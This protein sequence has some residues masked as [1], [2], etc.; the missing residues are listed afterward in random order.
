MK[1]AIALIL[2]FAMLAM[3]FSMLAACGKDDDDEGEGDPA[4]SDG[5]ETP[6]PTNPP[7]DPPE[8]DPPPPPPPPK[9]FAD[10]IRWNFAEI[11]DTDDKG[12]IGWGNRNFHMI[13]NFRVEGGILKM[14]TTG[15]DPFFGLNVNL[16][17]AA[18]EIERIVIRVLNKTESGGAEIFFDTDIAPGLAAERAFRS[19]YWDFGEDNDKWEEIVFFP[20]DCEF[21]EGTVNQLRVDI[22]EGAGEVWVEW[23]ALQKEVK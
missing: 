9:E 15:G 5:G 1:K 19:S 11:G 12:E 10:V 16:D 13:E 2:L 8:T 20:D 23:I 7:T 14:T 22:V 4:A 17:I 21:W 6:P 3:M 18:S